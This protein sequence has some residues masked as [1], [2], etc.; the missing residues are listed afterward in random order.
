MLC[1]AGRVPGVTIPILLAILFVPGCARRPDAR[2]ERCAILPF[3][4]L[5]DDASLDWAGPAIREA[6]VEQLAGSSR[7]QA[8]TFDSTGAAT[9]AGTATAVRGYFTLASG[10][11]RLEVSEE[12]L[13]GGKA[14][15]AYR[16]EADS[17]DGILRIADELAHR[18][19]PQAG[20]PETKSTEAL[21]DLV[22]GKASADPAAARAAFE[23]AIAAD[24]DFGPAYVALA[25]LLS[26]RGDTEGV[27][28][29]VMKANARRDSIPELR[30]AE[31]A[32]LG[33][34]ADGDAGRKRQALLVLTRLM[35]S[36]TG[37]MTTLATAETAAHRYGPA[38]EWYRKVLSLEPDSPLVWN[39]LGYVEA[40]RKDLAAAQAAL[41]E[42]QRLVP[43]EANPWDSMGD[44]HFHLGA[45][46]DAAKYYLQ[47]YEKDAAFLGSATLY[48]A[49]R[50]R[51]MTGDLSGADELFRRYVEARR[52]S[53]DRVVDYAAA[54]W[55]YLTGHRKDATE[56]MRAIAASAPAELKVLAEAQL[57]AWAAEEGN[58]DEAVRLAR[59]VLRTVTTPLATT[60]AVFTLLLADPNPPANIPNGSL[61]QLG[62]ACRSLLSQQYPEAESLLRPLLAEIDPLSQEQVNV[63]LA[64]ALIENG[65][66]AEAAPL[67]ET[68]AIPQS[69]LEPTFGSLTFPRVFLLK[70][71]VLSKQGQSKEA[72]QQRELYQRLSGG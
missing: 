31:L 13:A 8:K 45:F 32:A 23:R 59:G 39:E 36:D 28:D 52:K 20:T 12:R 9:A 10:R 15:S 27:K 56:R 2:V 25:R 46:P 21:R 38:A 5:T 34:T 53:G 55:L 68:Y 51:L 11:L 44:V 30:R 43:R 33:A 65:K 7:I 70:S 54:Q 35:P 57:S 62:E 67:L 40:R 6:A 4:N 60:T 24:P 63:L 47:A 69:G 48:K 58:K 29:V 71:E 72:A 37:V 19:D 22:E 26:A 17:A 64:W 3:E 18:L 49:A 61:K 50:A 16:I 14:A 1:R 66:V 42:Y 41:G